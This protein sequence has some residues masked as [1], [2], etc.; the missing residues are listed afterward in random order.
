MSRFSSSDLIPLKPNHR[1]KNKEKQD[2]KHARKQVQIAAR[3]QV[4]KQRMQQL[5]DEVPS[6]SRVIEIRATGSLRGHAAWIGKSQ[7]VKRFRK[8]LQR[9]VAG[10][11]GFSRKA[12][13]YCR[14]DPATVP[15]ETTIK[16]DLSV[17]FEED[18]AESLAER[19][20]P[21]SIA[22]A[23][24]AVAAHD[25]VDSALLLAEAEL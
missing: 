6:P 18:C 25:S 10:R 9:T 8:S 12:S 23:L 11:G 15:S 20:F 22:E 17:L 5:F 1:P 19:P 13:R 21:P 14:V 24:D 4:R 7:S 2:R 16:E 3:K